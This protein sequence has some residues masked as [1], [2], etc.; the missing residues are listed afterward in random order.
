MDSVPS[1]GRLPW[2]SS[3]V[4]FFLEGLHRT[5]LLPI[6]G[7]RGIIAAVTILPLASDMPLSVQRALAFLP[8]K[9]DPQA[10]ADARYS[11]DWRLDMWEGLYPQIP[12]HLLLGKGYGFNAEDFQFMGYDT[13]FHSADPSQQGLAL[14]MDYHSGWLSVLL[15]FGIWGMLAFLWFSLAGMYVL[16]CNFRYG[17]LEM[18]KLTPSCWRLS[19]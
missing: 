18:R 19:L 16:Y 2:R 15:T 11:L 6:F 5:K 10:A 12:R 7:A 4:Q 8:V 1:W 9:I 3:G 14:S 17:D 13:A